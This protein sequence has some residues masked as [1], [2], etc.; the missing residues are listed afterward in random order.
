MLYLIRH[1]KAGSRVAYKGD[2]RLRPL[3][4][5]GRRQAKALATRLAPMLKTTGVTTLYSS[6]FIR[7]IET[8]Q[9]LA[10]EIG[11]VI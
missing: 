3:N 2:D 8:L 9:P 1:A 7:C 10:K 6:P 4:G 11:A 5:P